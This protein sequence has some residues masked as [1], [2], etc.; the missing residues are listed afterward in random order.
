MSKTPFS[1]KNSDF[2]NAA[3]ALARKVIYPKFFGLPEEE[4][5]WDNDTLLE[6]GKRGE[7]LDGQMAIDRIVSIK[8]PLNY[9]NKNGKKYKKDNLIPFTI[10]ERFREVN[11]M[12][13][14]DLTITAWNTVSNMP[15]EMDKLSALLFVYGYFNPQKQSFPD[16]VVADTARMMIGLATGELRAAVNMNYRSKQLM[17]MPLFK[18]MDEFGCLYYWHGKEKRNQK[19]MF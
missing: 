14:Q 7:A 16:Y 3:H 12:R 2:S 8:R 5:D 18:D 19:S 13:F 6:V 15:S 10:Q 17:V 4:L 11:Y 9:T 1:R